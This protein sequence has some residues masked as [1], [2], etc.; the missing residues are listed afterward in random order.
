MK[1]RKYLESHTGQELR[2]DQPTLEQQIRRIA[3]DGAEEGVALALIHFRELLG[4][5]IIR[6]E[7]DHFLTIAEAAE[8]LRAS[9]PTARALI[10]EIG[11]RRVGGIWRIPKWAIRRHID[12]RLL[13]EFDDQSIRERAILRYVG[14]HEDTRDE[15]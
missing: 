3:R 10:Q 15:T 2:T 14:G 5:H 7:D 12:P 8:Y 11:I 9:A 1:R 4:A 13:E 6:T